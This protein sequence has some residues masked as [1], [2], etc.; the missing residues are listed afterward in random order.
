MK[1]Q[2]IIIASIVIAIGAIMLMIVY[3]STLAAAIA[4]SACTAAIYNALK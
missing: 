3:E 1:K 2:V 4:Y